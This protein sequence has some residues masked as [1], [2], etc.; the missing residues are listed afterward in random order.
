MPKTTENSYGN[1]WL[2]TF[3]SHGFLLH[4]CGY[5][6]AEAGSLSASQLQQ[7]MQFK[8][9]S[10]SGRRTCFVQYVAVGSDYPGRSEF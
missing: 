4:P 9:G 3:N 6:A 8:F 1:E 5:V 7:L 10:F 2:R